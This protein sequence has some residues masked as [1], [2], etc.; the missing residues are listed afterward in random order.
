MRKLLAVVALAFTVV[1]LGAC[2]STKEDHAAETSA[3][4]AAEG[5]E[6][7]GSAGTGASGATDASG[8]PEYCVKWGEIQGKYADAF[9][10]AQQP[11]RLDPT[12]PQA[13]MQQIQ[14][15][16]HKLL[17][18][19][20][21]FQAVAPAEI[22]ADVDALV[23]GLQAMADASPEGLA[24]AGPALT[25]AGTNVGQFLAA[26]CAGSAATSTTAAGNGTGSGS[27]TATGTAT[28]PG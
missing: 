14:D 6:T 7:S 8:L 18:P 11:P 21:E 13:A 24:T 4:P 23:N 1:G 20:Q 12:N 26:Q 10:E 16:G 3:T 22:K 25:T 19:M 2:S 17:A 5:P 27:G 28:G 9:K 15:V